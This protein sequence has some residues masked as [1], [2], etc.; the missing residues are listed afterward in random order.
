MPQHHPAIQCLFGGKLKQDCTCQ[1]C[2][3][4]ACVICG[5]TEATLTTDCAGK[6]LDPERVKELLETDLDYTDVRGWHVAK[7][8]RGARHVDLGPARFQSNLPPTA[9]DELARRAVAW[10]AADRAC[11]DLAA[12]LEPS[13][14]FDYDLTAITAIRVEFQLASARADECDEALRQAARRLADL[15]EAVPGTVTPEEY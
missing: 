2:T 9:V 10:A 14:G 8:P 11:E 1:L 12:K 13:M 3:H 6:R 15:D 4:P 7:Q 5:A